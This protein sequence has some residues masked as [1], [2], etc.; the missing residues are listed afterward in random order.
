MKASLFGD[1]RCGEAGVGLKQENCRVHARCCS[2][3][4]WLNARHDVTA[5][6]DVAADVPWFAWF[7]QALLGDRLV[8]VLS[9]PAA[10]GSFLAWPLAGEWPQAD[11]DCSE[12]VR[13]VSSLGAE[14]GGT[15]GR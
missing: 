5:Q 8:P 10:D 1:V 7:D 12:R 11:L 14:G 13:L 2:S 4:G 3:T 6:P 9:W 15:S